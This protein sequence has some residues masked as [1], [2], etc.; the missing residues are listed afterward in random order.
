MSD[1]G[2]L[3]LAVDGGTQSTKVLLVDAHGHVHARARVALRPL[4]RGSAGEAEHPDDDLWDSLVAAVR[5]TLDDWGGDPARVVALGL[6]S[7]RCCQV[8]LDE[9]GRLLAPV[10]SWMDR[11]TWQPWASD[12]L[13]ADDRVATVGAASAYLTARLTGERVDAAAAYDQVWLGANQA[14]AALL[15]P[16]VEAGEVLGGLTAPAAAALGLPAGLDVVATGNDKAVEALGAGMVAEEDAL[17]LSL[18]TYVAAMTPVSSGGPR[19]RAAADGT[20]TWLNDACPAGTQL[21]ETGGVRHGMG[22]VSWTARLVDQDVRALGE[23]ATEVP[24][25]AGGVIVAPDWLAPTDEPW[26]SG[27]VL[28]LRDAHGPA[29]LFRAVLEGLVLTMADHVRATED[30]L[31]HRFARIVL[32][33]GGASSPLMAAMVAAALDRPVVRPEQTDAAGLGAAVCAAVGAG[34]H[35]GWEAAVAAMVRRGPEETPAPALVDAYATLAPRH[36]AL[37][38]GVAAILAAAQDVYDHPA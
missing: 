18:G 23:A 26:R 19:E 30:D 33:G 22:T 5:T 29:H 7:I 6:C 25:G 12:E 36:R 17:L 8:V 31:G 27:A 9:A 10:R 24:P 20:A 4:A 1:A 35:G 2:P 37:R 38:E 28:G 32:T 16:V 34:L 13:V 3:L 14:P 21:A 11:R 15:P